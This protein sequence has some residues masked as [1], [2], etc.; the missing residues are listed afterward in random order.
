[1]RA[2][3]REPRQRRSRGKDTPL[4][5]GYRLLLQAPRLA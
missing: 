1:M 3:F 5:R 4:P 2:R